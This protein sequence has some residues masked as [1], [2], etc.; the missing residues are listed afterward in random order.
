MTRTCTAISALA[1][2]TLSNGFTQAQSVSPNVPASRCWDAATSQVR[3]TNTS[4]TVGPRAGGSRNNLPPAI[5][6]SR[7]GLGHI[8]I[9]PSAPGG[10]ATRPPEAA[11][12]PNC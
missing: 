3:S 6:S 4:G 8:P 5:D 1:V 9:S 7:N 11:S 12:L 2:L 10:I